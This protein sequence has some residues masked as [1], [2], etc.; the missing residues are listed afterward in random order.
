MAS[1]GG[2]DSKL[3][4]VDLMDIY[5]RSAKNQ[6]FNWRVVEV[7][8]G[9]AS[10][11]IEGDSVNKFY[12]NE[13]GA[14]CFSRIPPTER[15]GRTQTSIVKVA[16]MN[17]EKEAGYVLNRNDVTKNYIRSSK[18][19]GGQNLNKVSSCVQLIHIPTGIQ[20]KVQDTRDQTKNEIIAW[21]RLTQ[22]L[23]VIEDKNDREKID[24]K[25]K[26]QIGEHGRGNKRRTYRLKEDI[27]QDHI[28]GKS[29]R[30]KDILKGKIELLF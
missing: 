14:H 21:E 9:F 5:I 8:D 4:V 22:K 1:E 17:P 7:K 27:V 29:C 28:T 24:N 2:N 18:K 10:I 16:I 30:W 13:S 23:K 15:N 3:L 26:D 11:W 12:A 20:V 25:R 6:N 19:A